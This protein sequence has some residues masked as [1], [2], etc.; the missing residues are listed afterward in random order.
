M[1]GPLNS[2]RKRW[3]T[4]IASPRRAQ[5]KWDQPY[6]TQADGWREVACRGCPQFQAQTQ[7]CGVNFGTPLRKCV[8][9]SIEAHLHDGQTK[10]T[11]QQAKTAQTLKSRKISVL[12]AQQLTKLL[13]SVLS[14]KPFI[15]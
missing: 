10:R 11:E 3:H 8:V 7:R 6:W 12:H 1:H 9:S 13:P 2:I 14:V 4:L 15:T 5:R